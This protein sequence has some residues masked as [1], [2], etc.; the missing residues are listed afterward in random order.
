MIWDDLDL[1]VTLTWGMMTWGD[2]TPE[3]S[4]WDATACISSRG[5]HCMDQVGVQ[6]E[7]RRG[8]RQL[9][10][11]HLRPAHPSRSACSAK[12]TGARAPWL[13]CGPAGVSEAGEQM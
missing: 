6:T 9:C 8:P 11:S 12:A 7:L 10:A 3:L 5:G 1:G 2:P 4:L 13:S